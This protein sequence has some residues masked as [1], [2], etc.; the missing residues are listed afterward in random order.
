MM[1]ENQGMKDS[2]NCTSKVNDETGV[3]EEGS[4][5]DRE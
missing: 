5:R 2:W 3:D 4:G 1:V